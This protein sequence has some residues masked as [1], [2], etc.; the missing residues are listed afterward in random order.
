MRGSIRKRG[1][2]WQVRVYAGV[3]EDSGAK[4]TISRT[5]Q[6]TKREAEEALNRLLLEVGDGR[7]LP[8]GV[9]L[10]DL[11]DQWWAVK[12]PTV[13]PTT[14]R[15]WDSCLR[16]HVRPHV[17]AVPLH[18]LRAMDLDRLYRRLLDAGVGAARVRRVH[19][20]LST[21]L[22]QAVRWE[23]I[24]TNPALNATPPEVREREIVPPEPEWLVAF[25]QQV[26]ADDPE[27]GMFIWL[28]AM[29]GARR[30]E[31]CALRWVDVNLYDHS[32]LIKRALV[33]AGGELIEKDTK[34][35]QVR[36]I[37]IGGDTGERLAAHRQ[38]CE[39]VASTCGVK[40]A[41]DAHVFARDPQGVEP[42]RP[43]GATHRFVDA[44]RKAG[45]GDD[46]RLHDLRHF[47]ATRMIAAGVDV[48]TVS[49]RLGHRRTSTTTDRYAAFVP[50]ADRLAADGFEA[51]LRPKG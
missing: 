1:S 38:R 22:G 37:A 23:M 18:K 51:A 31:L 40:L 20:V 3:Y 44:R 28:A 50:A 21:A 8:S 16:L 47:L 39:E 4:R 27:F 34:T 32:I 15:D 49:G 25:Q 9:T 26:Q 19:T 13:S 46:V 12:R 17:S 6:G 41:A 43:D 42:W 36:R 14:A 33:D 45:L 48:R 24:V 2:G 7:H 5:V 10:G 35:H 30:G 11:L 29:T